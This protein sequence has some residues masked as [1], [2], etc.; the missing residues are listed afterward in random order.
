[1]YLYLDS[2][3][4]YKTLIKIEAGSTSCFATGSHVE[5]P[6]LRSEDQ[7]KTANYYDKINIFASF[8]LLT[9]DVCNE[10]KSNLVFQKKHGS[11]KN[12]EHFIVERN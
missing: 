8:C 7:V 3:R 4:Q 1:M 12:K 9:G 6:H 10:I 11:E 5:R 2:A